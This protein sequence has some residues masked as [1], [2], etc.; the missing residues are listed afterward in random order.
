M[1]L[2]NMVIIDLIS[3]DSQ[4]SETKGDNNGHSLTSVTPSLKQGKDLSNTGLA[5]KS[6]DTVILENTLHS[7]F[8]GHRMQTPSCS[9]YNLA[10]RGKDL[11][12]KGHSATAAGKLK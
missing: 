11:H 4:V 3:S 2:L 5:N 12:N 9:S 6:F 1:T 10:I 7:S 8:I